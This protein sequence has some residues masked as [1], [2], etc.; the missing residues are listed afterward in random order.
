MLPIHAPGPADDDL[1]AALRELRM[2]IARQ[3][4]VPPYVVFTDATLQEMARSQPQNLSEMLDISGVGEV[5]LERYGQQFLEVIQSQTAIL[6]PSVSAV[7]TGDKQ[8]SGEGQT[9]LAP[10]QRPKKTSTHLVSYQLYQEG[11]S[12][13]EIAG[14]RELTLITV[15]NHLLRAFQDGYLVDWTPFLTPEQEQQIMRAA[16]DLGVEKLKPLKEALPQ[17]ISYFMIKIALLRHSLQGAYL[18]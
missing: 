16:G 13:A 14:E 18:A 4:N 15:Q 12:L 9:V 1:F 7:E 3:E 11:K 6:P 8:A 10:S 5:K 2:T 17:D